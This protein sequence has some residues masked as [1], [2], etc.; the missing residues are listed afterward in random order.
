M[1]MGIRGSRG[2]PKGGKGFEGEVPKGVKPPKAE[3]KPPRRVSEANK[4]GKGK[5]SKSSKFGRKALVGGTLGAL[6]L[7][8][9]SD[10]LNNKGNGN[11]TDPN[12]LSRKNN[13]RTSSTATKL[14]SQNIVIKKH[15][16]PNTYRV[17]LNQL[18]NTINYAIKRDKISNRKTNNR[19]QSILCKKIMDKLT[20]H[21][22]IQNDLIVNEIYNL[23]A[24]DNE[25]SETTKKSFINNLID[26]IKPKNKGKMSDTFLN[27]ASLKE[28]KSINKTQTKIYMALKEL[29]EDNLH[30]I[31]DKKREHVQRLPYKQTNYRNVSN[32]ENGIS[33]FGIGSRGFGGLIG[34]LLTALGGGALLATYNMFNNSNNYENNTDTNEKSGLSDSISRTFTAMVNGIRYDTAKGVRNT[35]KNVR[36]N[37]NETKT[38][39]K[40]FK[41]QTEKRIN[42]KNLAKR[43]MESQKSRINRYKK[44]LKNETNP[45]IKKQ[46]KE[47][48]NKNK[49]LLKETKKIWKN[50]DKKVIIKFIKVLKGVKGIAK[51]LGAGILLSGLELLLLNYELEHLDDLLGREATEEDKL[52]LEAITAVEC[53]PVVGFIASMFELLPALLSLAGDLITNFINPFLE[54]MVNEYQRNKSSKFMK[55]I[56]SYF[57]EPMGYIIKTILDY[58]CL[59]IQLV[60]PVLEKVGEFLSCINPEVLHESLVAVFRSYEIAERIHISKNSFLNNLESEQYIETKSWGGIGDTKVV[61]AEKLNDLSIAQLDALLTNDDQTHLLNA[62]SRLQIE[63]VKNAKISERNSLL[64]KTND[65][66]KD[67]WNTVA[68]KELNK[69]EYGKNVTLN[70]ISNLNNLEDDRI[71]SR[72]LLS[73]VKQKDI[74]NNEQTKNIA[75]KYFFHWAWKNFIADIRNQKNDIKYFLVPPII[76]EIPKK[77]NENVLTIF[78]GAGIYFVFLYGTVARKKDEDKEPFYGNNLQV[79]GYLKTDG[80]GCLS[81]KAVNDDLESFNYYNNPKYKEYKGYNQYRKDLYNSELTPVQEPK[82]QKQN[83]E[84]KETPKELPE[85]YVNPDPEVVVNQMGKAYVERMIG[86]DVKTPKPVDTAP[87]TDELK[88]STPVPKVLHYTKPDG[89]TGTTNTTAPKDDVFQKVLK[90]TEIA[91][92]N[93]RFDRYGREKLEKQSTGWC[94]HYVSNALQASGLKFNR[95]HYAH[96]YHTKGILRKLGFN[97][98]HSGLTDYKAEAG[99]ICVVN[100]FKAGGKDHYHV[101]IYDG[102]EWISDFTQGK[103]GW[104]IYKGGVRP[105]NGVFYYRYGAS[106]IPAPTV[107]A[108][109]DVA[110]T[111]DTTKTPEKQVPFEPIV[112]K[113]KVEVAKNNTK[114]ADTRSEKTSKDLAV[115]ER[116]LN[117]Q[118]TASNNNDT[119]LFDVKNNSFFKHKNLDNANVFFTFPVLD[120]S[121]LDWG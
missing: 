63:N 20:L 74:L 25:I 43:T 94:A 34:G 62:E 18:S 15:D 42:E 16:Y 27:S 107:A 110:E 72:G 83:V 44:D 26:L 66:E 70:N 47:R 14:V 89:T 61:N 4:G 117:E 82:V 46:I 17:Q 113:E 96:E 112:N 57:P 64:K 6:A 118:K 93:T 7:K 13:T 87:K 29:S 77:G 108:N 95:P 21:T 84:V 114:D 60:L 119:L 3:G 75:T 48:I 103:S 33:N 73:T 49:V 56:L 41:T 105:N 5:P 9:V 104:N 69:I 78:G 32:I 10:L 79:L 38:S 12:A 30:S 92:K 106:D 37:I 65:K 88:V 121:T 85:K 120:Y 71:A 31:Y 81:D 99:D 115:N 76:V 90:A 86:K 51:S 67:A 19:Y 39:Y 59:S 28:L 8:A 22:E 97:M 2:S 68:I 36:A 52:A 102:K 11:G 35:P 91:R 50:A 58:M 98:V 45:E 116:K 101:A 1:G 80:T 24:L 55:D 23:M 54:Y 40:D 109:T 100:K 53:V 111:F